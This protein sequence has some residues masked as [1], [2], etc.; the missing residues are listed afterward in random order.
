MTVELL[1]FWGYVSNNTNHFKSK[2][3]S[4]DAEIGKWIFVELWIKLNIWCFHRKCLAFIK[5]SHTDI[6]KH[7]LKLKMYCNCKLLHLHTQYIHTK[8]LKFE[9]IEWFRA[10]GAC[11]VPFRDRRHGWTIGGGRHQIFNTGLTQNNIDKW[12]SSLQG[13]ADNICAAHIFEA[14]FSLMLKTH[15]R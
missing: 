7:D 13:N 10:F 12:S 2:M 15:N 4:M 11:A 8:I 9:F 3:S 5:M 6:K 14:R 1:L